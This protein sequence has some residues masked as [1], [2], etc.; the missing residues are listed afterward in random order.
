[1][2]RILP[3]V[4][5]CTVLSCLTG[6]ASAKAKKQK[7]GPLTGTWECMSHGSSQ[8]DIP[9]TLYLDQKKEN[10]T[11]SVSSPQGG[12]DITS[13]TFK[14]NML[15]IHLETPQ[16]NHVLMGELKKGQL[17]GKWSGA[18]GQERGSWEGKKKLEA[19]R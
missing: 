1:M 12:M 9:F 18:D 5:L 16:G 8:G 7:P 4:G 15:E 2:K 13:G 17:S 14:K 11:G 6:S 19:K 10:V 3:L